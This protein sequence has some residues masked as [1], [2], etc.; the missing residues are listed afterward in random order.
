MNGAD[1][2][3]FMVFHTPDL[4]LKNG[5]WQLAYAAKTTGIEQ[6]YFII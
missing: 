6:I 1:W 5:S 3:H 4:D 2:A